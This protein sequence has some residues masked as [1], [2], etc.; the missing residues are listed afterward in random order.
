MVNITNNEFKCIF[1]IFFYEISFN[2]VSVHL[3]DSTSTLI[4]VMAWHQKGNKLLPELMMTK[5]H[6]AIG[7]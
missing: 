2:F 5:L 6:G 1:L 4:Q 3:I 7:S